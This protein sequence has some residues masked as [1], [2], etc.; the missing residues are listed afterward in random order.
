MSTEDDVK[1]LCDLSKLEIP[2]EMIMETA[3]KVKDVLGLFSKLDEFT[4]SDFDLNTVNDLRI[5]KSID[6]L[7]AD[8]LFSVH[9]DNKDNKFDFKPLNS[10]NGFIIGPRI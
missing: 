8:T 4:N 5:E 6:S 7:R 3:K 10:K 2:D 1:K 9:V